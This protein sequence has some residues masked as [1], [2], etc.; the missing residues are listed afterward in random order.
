MAETL[1]PWRDAPQ[2]LCALA[3]E[4]AAKGWLPATSGNLSVCVRQ[5]PLALAITRSGADKQHLTPPDVI[6]VD[7]ELR[8]LD[9]VDPSHRPSAETI[10]HTKLYQALSCGCILHVHTVYNN[11]A[12]E[13]YFAEGAVSIAG[14]ELLKALDHWEPDACIQVPIVE[15]LH[16]IPALADAVLAAVRPGVPGVLVRNHGIYAWG[17]TP[18]AAKRYL[19]AFEF[20]FQYVL[21]LR[22]LRG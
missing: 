13:V 5:H 2:V 21:T 16:D 1:T 4:L 22:L 14:H 8:V 17:D 6:Y 15:N 18:A 3:D 10:V 20:L 19:E 7:S 9:A 11:L 12:S